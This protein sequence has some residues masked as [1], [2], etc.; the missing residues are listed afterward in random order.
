MNVRITSVNIMSAGANSGLCFRKTSL[1]IADPWPADY[2]CLAQNR[3]IELISIRFFTTASQFLSAWPTLT[4]DAC[5]INV[6][7]PDLSGFDLVEMIQPFPK[8]TIVCMLADTYLVEDEVRALSL[9]VHSYLCKPL[10]AAVFFDLCLCS[11]AR[12]AGP[13]PAV[14]SPSIRPSPTL[15]V[16]GPCH[17]KL[18]NMERRLLN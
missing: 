18:R 15:R 16:N 14:S 3:R 8:R 6:N 13:A 10:E 11:R 5:L 17:C 9:G 2:D 7:L 4:P 12:R 1:W